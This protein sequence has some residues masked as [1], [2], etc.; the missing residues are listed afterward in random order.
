MFPVAT[1]LTQL[2]CNL[3]IMN[4][5]ANFPFT[6][7]GEITKDFWYLTCASMF[8]TNIMIVWRLVDPK[9][10]VHS[11]R[12]LRSKIANNLKNDALRAEFEALTQQAEFDTKVADIRKKVEVL[13]H[14][15]FGHSQ[16]K[17][18]VKQDPFLI[19]EDSLPI[20]DLEAMAS[21]LSDLFDL[22]CFGEK[23]SLYLLDY[24]PNVVYP[25]KVHSSDIERILDLVAK[26]SS[27]VNMPERDLAWPY[28]KKQLDPSELRMMLHFRKKFGLSD[29]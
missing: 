19:D 22:L 20:S 4:K 5:I 3:H 14:N 2:N 21:T 9:K 16:I 27:L 18:M 15:R 8:E 17:W 28:L 6:E 12:N 24:D 11:I 26:E 10:N 29:V 23:R 13:R 7:L 25:E 1:Q